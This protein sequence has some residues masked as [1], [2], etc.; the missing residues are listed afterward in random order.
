MPTIHPI[1]RARLCRSLAAAV[2]LHCSTA[3]AQLSVEAP[4]PLDALLLQHLQ[5]PAAEAG[6]AALEAFRRNTR[7]TVAELLATEGYFSPDVRVR[8]TP[9]ALSV[10]VAPGTRTVV[11][12]AT[13]EIRGDVPAE[14]RDALRAGWLLPPGRPFRDA[15]W[16]EAK[17]SL[18]R[19]LLAVDFAAAKLADSRA[20][21]D[22]L[23]AQARL[24]AVYDAGPRYVVDGVRISGL[25]RYSPNLVRRYGTIAP[26]SR[27]D[28]QE[29]LALQ[30]ALQ[31][32]PYFSSVS[33]EIAQPEEAPRGGEVRVP[34]NIHVQERKP[35]RVSFGLGVSTNTGAQAEAIYQGWDFLHRA[36]QLDAGLRLEQ[37]RQRLY[38]DIRL[39]PEGN[40]RDSFG[41]LLDREDIQGL[42]RDRVAFGAVRERMHGEIE[43]R[44]ALN[45]QRETREPEDAAASTSRAVTLDGAWT[46]RRVDDALDP[47]RGFMA[48]LQ[49][50][51]AAKAV[52]SDQNFLRLHARYQQF[53]PLGRRDV[54]TLR[55]ELGAT[56]AQ[57]REGIP[58][59]F[60]FRAGG[61]QSV[62]GYR[63]Q[64]LGVR[65]GGAVVGGRYL[66]VASAEY[67]HWFSPQ[68]GGAV[69]VDAGDAA[70]DRRAL[71]PAVGY[72]AGARW[73]SPAGP[74]AVDLAYGERDRKARLHLA[75]S[76]AF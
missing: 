32:A 63:Y 3:G 28:E 51:G 46:L 75:L 67:I 16:T 18:L 44:Y 61:A 49:A 29:L 15:D 50:G 38:A 74:L 35:H 14:R 22:P 37:L 12:E 11:A 21:V 53:F 31:R 76:I 48:R 20:E 23:A 26:G 25:S 7:R 56:L 57:S 1:L 69:F 41:A 42:R 62:R 72:G 59:D 36:W 65:E 40:R 10:E 60:L 17:Q 27:Y 54:L 43:A 64:S 47:R 2:G 58:Q 6:E 5:P 39:P 52:L 8:A 66:A 45:W 70:D 68:W 33:V 4:A 55:A 19:R 13:V 9:G 24:R 71:K 34:V 30:E 73:K